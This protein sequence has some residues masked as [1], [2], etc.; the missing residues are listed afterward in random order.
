[1]DAKTATNGSIAA[2]FTGN[3]SLRPAVQSVPLGPEV[4]PF[5]EFFKFAFGSAIYIIIASFVTVLAN[6]LLLVVFFF[7]PLKTFRT[8]T[9]YFLIGL[10]FVDILTAASQEPMYATCFIMMYLRHPDTLAT[11]I[12]LLNVGQ[13]IA[14]AAMNA[15]FL[16]VLAFTITQ[17]I[18]VVSPLKYGRRVTKSRVVICVLGIYAYSILF[19]LFP[20]MGIAE[21][22]VQKI[23]NIFHSITLVY[24]TIIFYILLYVAFRKKMAASKS[25]QE[26]KTKQDRGREN[27]QTGVERKFIIINFLL[28]AILFLTSQPSAVLWIYRL[29]S[30]ENPNAP[31][32][33]IVNLMLA[34][35]LI[36]LKFLLDPFVYAWRIPRYRRALKYVMRCGREEPEE[37]F[38]DRVIA[39]VSK[40][41]ETVVALNFKC[42]KD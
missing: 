12:P 41:R 17:Y 36:Y 19:S 14:V 1:M 33:L 7:D 2:N 29:Y 5:D 39:Q 30:N 26:H 18:V 38:S 10:A 21:E 3:L 32:V 40:S 34:D 11:C 13:V 37:T 23:D 4:S 15:S 42:I 16:I 27:K 9:T 20:V 8:A 25:L 22:I 31:S 28:I 24:V 6:G 35:N